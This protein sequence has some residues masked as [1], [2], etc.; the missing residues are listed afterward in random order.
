MHQIDRRRRGGDFV[1]WLHL[2][3]LT[4]FSRVPRP[5]ADARTRKPSF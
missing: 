4:A 5:V 2:L 1:F 3:A